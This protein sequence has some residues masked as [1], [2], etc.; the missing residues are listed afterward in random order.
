MDLRT[1]PRTPVRKGIRKRPTELVYWYLFDGR[2]PSRSLQAIL[3]TMAE[4]PWPFSPLVH[5]K[6]T[7]RRTLVSQ[8]F[9]PALMRG[10]HASKR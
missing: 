7:A 4:R 1:L 3:M 6:Y 2:I 10:H 8:R 9:M 5:W